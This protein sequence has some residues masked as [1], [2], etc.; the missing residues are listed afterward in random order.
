[1]LVKWGARYE[2]FAVENYQ[3]DSGYLVRVEFYSLVLLGSS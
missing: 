3:I 1:M 2:K